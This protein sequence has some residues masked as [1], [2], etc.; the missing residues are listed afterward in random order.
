MLLD[1]A[2]GA[3]PRANSTFYGKVVCDGRFRELPRFAGPAAFTYPAFT[4]HQAA[5]FCIVMATEMESVAVGWHV[6]EITNDSSSDWL[7]SGA[8]S[9]RILLFW[10]PAIPQT[11]MTAAGSLPWAMGG[12]AICSGMLSR[13]ALGRLGSID[14]DLMSWW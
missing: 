2:H 4:L 14:S 3:G 8:I 12:F 7:A 11:A 13:S 6:Y 9:S 10:F 5:R 1:K